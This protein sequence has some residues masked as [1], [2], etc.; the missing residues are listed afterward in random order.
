MAFPVTI[1]CF[2]WV[3][4]KQMNMFHHQITSG[5]MS[6]SQ[7]LCQRHT[8]GTLK[9]PWKWWIS[10]ETHGDPMLFSPWVNFFARVWF[11][12]HL[13]CI[14]LWYI[15]YH[16]FELGSNT[17][18]KSSPVTLGFQVHQG[19]ICQSCFPGTGVPPPSSLFLELLTR[20]DELHG[21]L[22]NWIL[23]QLKEILVK[24]NHSRDLCEQT[25]RWVSGRAEQAESNSI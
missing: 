9:L 6:V 25:K 8:W 21:I 22:N 5:H 1:N 11:P 2:A 17:P 13:Y 15:Q 14:M 18:S 12:V 20:G 4:L 19:P 10:W 24:K 23:W 16:A 7:K 3:K